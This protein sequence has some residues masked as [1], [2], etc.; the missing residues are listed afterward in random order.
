MTSEQ[1]KRSARNLHIDFQPRLVSKCLTAPCG[2]CGIADDLSPALLFIELTSKRPFRE[3]ISVEVFTVTV[4]GQDGPYS[5]LELHPHSGEKIL[6]I[7]VAY[8]RA[9]IISIRTIGALRVGP[10]CRLGL[11]HTGSSTTSR[12]PEP[13]KTLCSFPRRSLCR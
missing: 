3:L 9:V 5:L 11:P 7:S 4:C 1:N 10:E 13:R 2:L 8:R 6:E 12:N